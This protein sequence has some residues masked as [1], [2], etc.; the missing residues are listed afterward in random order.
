[1]SLELG[2]FAYSF[3]SGFNDGAA[4]FKLHICSPVMMMNEFRIQ[5]SLSYELV[6]IVKSP[7]TTVNAVNFVGLIFCVWQHKHIFAG[8]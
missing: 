7:L 6:C 8:C 4:T 5:K 2:N 1:M 3:I